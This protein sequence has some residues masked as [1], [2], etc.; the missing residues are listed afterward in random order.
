MVVSVITAIKDSK[1][2]TSSDYLSYLSTIDLFRRVVCTESSE[3]FSLE[4]KNHVSCNHR[5]NLSR[6]SSS[7]AHRLATANCRLSFIGH[8]DYAFE[9]SKTSTAFCMPISTLDRIDFGSP[10][11]V[12]V[13]IEVK[14]QV[15][16]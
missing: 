15:G 16:L 8:S 10:R 13:V 1:K 14:D 5:V 6:F 4:R 12:V 2:V 11:K 9:V 7:P 3:V